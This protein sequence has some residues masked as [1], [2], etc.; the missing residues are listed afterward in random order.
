MSSLKRQKVSHKASTV[1]ESRVAERESSPAQSAVS[2]PEAEGEVTADAA[3][4]VTKSFKDLGVVDSLCDACANLGYTKP[5][6]IQAQSIPHALAN[7]DIIGLAETG[8]GKTAAF[9]LPV[10]QA[11]LEKPQAFFGLVLAP[12]RELAAQ[13]GQQFEALGSLISLRTAVIVGGLDM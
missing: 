6:P 2:E 8:S 12:T 4:E 1:K 5:T 13:I 11:L 3:E 9:A 7:R 10:I